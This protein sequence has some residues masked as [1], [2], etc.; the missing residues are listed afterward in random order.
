MILYYI[1]FLQLQILFCVSTFLFLS[2]IEDFEKR[3]I[4]KLYYI[5]CFLT[6]YN[7]KCTNSAA[8]HV[9]R[10]RTFSKRPIGLVCA[11]YSI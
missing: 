10:P 11:I 1:F 9:R 8:A 6:H 5:M 4:N 3:S 2:V 7:T